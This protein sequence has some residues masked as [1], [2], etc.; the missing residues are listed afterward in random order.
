MKLSKYLAGA[1]AL[2]LTAAMPVMAGAI[3][4][5]EVLRK[6]DDNQVSKTRWFASKMT[7]E[8]GGKTLI[9]EM[10]GYGASEGNKFLITFTNA[11]DRGVKYLK[12]D[13]NLWIYLPD[14]DDV[15]KISGHMLRQGMMGS[16]LSYEDML[17]LEQLNKK[18][19]A[20]LNGETQV[21]GVNCHVLEIKAKVPDVTYYREVICVDA[22]RFL[23]LRIELYAKSGRLLKTMES[24]G[25]KEQKGRYYSTKTVIKD[26]KRKDS[27]TTLDL[28]ELKLDAPVPKDTFTRQNLSK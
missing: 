9:K 28:I 15:M 11:E 27:L 24:S 10:Q 20:S 3:T 17:S 6:L 2:F 19:S 25:I 22:K 16:D 8:K 12:L 23:P 7:I 13:E 1:M 26:M 18:Y 4:A 21:S 5:D 14:A